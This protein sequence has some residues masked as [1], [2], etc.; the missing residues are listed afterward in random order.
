MNTADEVLLPI[1]KI[2]QNNEVCTSVC[3]LSLH[4]RTSKATVSILL[5][6]MP[7]NCNAVILKGLF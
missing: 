4:K 6:C 7:F 1:I 3:M 5:V 2:V